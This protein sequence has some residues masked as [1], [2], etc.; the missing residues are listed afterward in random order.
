MSSQTQ[1][2]GYTRNSRLRPIEE[3]D[4]AG[5]LGTDGRPVDP[6]G[7]S[8]FGEPDGDEYYEY[9]LGVGDRIRALGGRILVRVGWCL[10][11]GALAF[12]GAGIVAAMSRP[13]TSTNRPELTY[14]ADNELSVRLDAAVRDL[15]LLNDDVESLGNQTRNA[16]ASLAQVNKVDLQS[17]WDAGSNDVNSIEARASALS[18]Q[19]S[20]DS[21]D[22]GLKTQLLESYSP[23]MIDRYDTVCQAVAS[24]APLRSNW[25]SLVEGSQRAMQVATDINDHDQVAAQALQL[26]NQARYSDALTELGKAADSISDA[27]AIA[28]DMAGTVDVST[29]QEWLSRTK[30]MD[31]A[32][33]VLWQA[34][35]DSNGKV[36]A[37]VTAALKNVNAAKALLP[38]S[39]DVMTVS[40]HEMAGGLTSDG[41]A[42]E[43]AKGTLASAL[44]A[45]AETD[46]TG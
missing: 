9:E 1:P 41:I 38:D 11:A 42:I 34:M 18:R 29:L 25:E 35:V 26:A 3:W 24:V 21:W 4:S 30:D 46:T 8:D 31:D 14:E 32:L 45:L 2:P 7:E 33:T 19:L 23:G 15:T 43:E 40:L 39:T 27:T 13:P 6:Y 28:S 20:C 10:L 17:A 36:T 12:G 22:T 37:Q 44:A 16:V 5:H